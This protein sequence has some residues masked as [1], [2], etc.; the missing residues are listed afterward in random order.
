M[1]INME[2]RALVALGL[3]WLGGVPAMA[4]QAAADVDVRGVWSSLERTG[5]GGISG[6]QMIFTSK[7]A[8]LTEGILMDASYRVEDNRIEVTPRDERHGTAQI[9]EFR[10]AG[11][12]MRM[13]LDGARPRIMTRAGKILFGS[14]PIVGEWSWPFLSKDWRFV[15]R[16]SRNGAS[17]LALP[18]DIDRG[19]YSITGDTMELDVIRNRDLAKSRAFTL[20]VRREGNLLTT[21][22]ADGVEKRFVKFEYDALVA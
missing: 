9:G 17:Q 5:E 1:P 15:Q 18:L 11:N 16:F 6:E 4:A 19:V 3:L 20:T 7:F 22:D 14:D 10:I 8:T 12:T 13:F 21:R 2:R